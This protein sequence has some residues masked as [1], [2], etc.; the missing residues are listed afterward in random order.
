M[1]MGG[2]GGH[3]AYLKVVIL[4]DSSS[5]WVI[6]FLYTP[7]IFFQYCVVFTL[8]WNKYSSSLVVCNLYGSFHELFEIL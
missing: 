3:A 6:V 4:S 2:G 7:F 5:Q 1:V 8:L